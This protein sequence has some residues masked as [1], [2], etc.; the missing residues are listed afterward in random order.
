[1]MRIHRSNIAIVWILL[2]SVFLSA[3]DLFG[4]SAKERKQ[5]EMQNTRRLV[6]ERKRD[7]L[8]G[9]LAIELTG[10]EQG[11]NGFRENT[12]AL[13]YSDRETS[14]VDR[15]EL[16]KRKLSMYEKGQSYDT[17]PAEKARV[18]TCTTRV[19]ARV[20]PA[21]MLGHADLLAG[22]TS[23]ARVWLYASIPILLGVIML[24]RLR[25]RRLLNAI[26][27]ENNARRSKFGKTP[28]Y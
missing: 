12:P 9:D 2:F 4:Q 27:N 11:D 17:V 25:K 13:L 5:A 21:S 20:A 19:Q 8:R 22:E 6:E 15:N 23:K 1:M 3:N 24:M 16:Y 7:E 28:L 26:E 10:L 14:I 18:T